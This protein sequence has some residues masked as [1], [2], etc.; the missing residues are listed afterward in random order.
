MS[1]STLAFWGVLWIER[2]GWACIG[3]SLRP[4]I[5]IGV[6]KHNPQYQLFYC[7]SPRRLG[8]NLRAHLQIRW[9]SLIGTAQ[10]RI[11]ITYLFLTRLAS[12]WDRKEVQV[13][14]L[15]D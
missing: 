5:G 6:S 12:E 1:S 11:V 15:S 8:S 14:M 7:L 4:P 9:A 3:P 10:I 2:N 13:V